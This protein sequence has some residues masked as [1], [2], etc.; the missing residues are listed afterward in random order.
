M[1]VSPRVIK[2]RIKSVAN[3]RKITKAMELVSASKMRKAVQLAM[4]S[5]DYSKTVTALIEDV[6][7]LIDPSTHPLLAGRVDAKSTLVIVAASDRGLCGSFNSQ[8]LKKTIEF[9]SHR[10]EKLRVITVGRRAEQSVRRA[11]VEIEAAF[12]AI[13]NAPTFERTT[14]I[15]KLVYSQFLSGHADRVFL[16][17]TD[18]KNAVTQIPTINQLLPVIPEDE[19]KKGNE[20]PEENDEFEETKRTESE[21]AG[22]LFEPDPVTVLDTLLPRLI[23]MRIYQALLESAASEHSARMLAMKNATENA[24]EMLD[25]LTLTYN[26]ARQA[27]ITREISEISAGKAAIE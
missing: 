9:L 23:D 20:T 6:R 25:D 26:Q 1:A 16:A 21:E 8:I 19:L 11:G 3:T 2:R 10:S 22:I 27:N 5:R 17:Y 15:G 24:S 14:P 4:S 18:F 7:G 12:E 13:S